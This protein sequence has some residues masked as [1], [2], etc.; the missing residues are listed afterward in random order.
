MVLNGKMNKKTNWGDLEPR[1]CKW[2]GNPYYHRAKTEKAGQFKK[3]SFCSNPCKMSSLP[4]FNTGKKAHNNNQK[5]RTCVWCGKKQ[6]VAPAYLARPFCSRVCMGKWMSKNMTGNKAGH[7]QGGKIKRNCLVCNNEFEF[8]KGELNR[9]TV[10]RVFCSM[11]CKATYYSLKSR[12]PN[13]KGGITPE[14][15]I[16]RNS[17]EAKEWKAAVLLRDEYTCQKCDAIEE[18]HV[19]HIK[20]FSKFEDLRFV[21]SNG[22]TLCKRCHYEV[23]SRL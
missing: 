13:W 21:I 23:H 16:M 17:K 9:R 4:Q 15:Q 11:S 1:I 10:S 2:C 22:I 3:R 5:E 19:H 12:N 20:P 14:N 7:W 18:L 6:M 8:D